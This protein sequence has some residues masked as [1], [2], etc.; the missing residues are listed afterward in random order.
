MHLKRNLIDIIGI[1]YSFTL[2]SHN[3]NIFSLIFF[4]NIYLLKLN[5][6]I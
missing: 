1:D 3:I 6:F 2:K 5:N 4:Q